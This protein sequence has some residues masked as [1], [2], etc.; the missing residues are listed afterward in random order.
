MYPYG[1]NFITDTKPREKELDLLTYLLFLGY[2][3]A[4]VSADRTKLW[5][6]LE[7]YDVPQDQINA[8]RSVYK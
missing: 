1:C 6:V 3:T 8:I 2:K 5:A 4:Y 7:S